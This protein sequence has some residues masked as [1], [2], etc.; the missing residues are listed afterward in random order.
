[1][2]NPRRIK[3]IHKINSIKFSNTFSPKFTWNFRFVVAVKDAQ[4]FYT[5]FYP[6]K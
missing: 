4:D 1:M 5:E 6:S 2:N 3:N